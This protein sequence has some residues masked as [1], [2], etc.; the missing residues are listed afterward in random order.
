MREPAHGARA[1]GPDGAG[2]RR[3]RAPP[4]PNPGTPSLSPKPRSRHV[5]GPLFRTNRPPK[6]RPSPPPLPRRPQFSDAKE[7]ELIRGYRVVKADTLEL[8]FDAPGDYTVPEK[9]APA[10]GA[11]AAEAPEAAEAA[12]AGGGDTAREAAHEL[13]AA[14]FAKVAG[15]K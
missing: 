7:E 15:A 13:A 12:A 9:R 6:P 8:V 14:V 1:G 4:A 10:V 5:E 11:A 3:L 2:A